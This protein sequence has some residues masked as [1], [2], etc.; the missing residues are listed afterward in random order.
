LTPA[1][2]LEA[3]KE[4]RAGLSFCLSL[5]L[6]LPHLGA[7]P[8][9][10]LPPRLYASA[11]EHTPNYLAEFRTRDPALTDV[12]C[13]DLVV[14]WLQYSTQWDSLGHMGYLFDADGD[15]H[16]EVVFYNGWR[17][18]TD[19]QGPTRASA[20]L[21]GEPW[22]RYEAP[23]AH[24]LGIEVLATSCVQGPA[25]LI[26]LDRAFGRERP[27]RVDHPMLM[28]AIVDQA[29]VIRPGDM[30]CLHTGYSQAVVDA[31]ARKS[32]AR[33]P[34]AGAT[35]DGRDPRLLRWITESQIV[36]LISDHFAVETVPSWPAGTAPHASAPLHEHCLFK[37]GVHLGELW[38]FRELAAWLRRNNRHRF[39][40]TAPPL[41]LP[42][43]V[44]SPVSPVATV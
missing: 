27:V 40:L 24:R 23:Y 18:G 44:G 12:L 4:V 29:V 38:D 28:R 32:T 8:V 30:V 31:A 36:A 6:D 25:V 14:M 2:L 33:L 21:S 1:R 42:G 37:L 43:A 19:I 11:R 10:R 17:G 13:D 5:P 39:L 16:E 15:G 35:L 20:T 34:D 9:S 41:R 3:I 7:L 22:T 26:D